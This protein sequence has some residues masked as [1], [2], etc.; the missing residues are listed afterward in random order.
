MARTG[1]GIRCKVDLNIQIIKNTDF[2]N[3]KEFCEATGLS[4][5]SLKCRY[6]TVQTMDTLLKYGID[7]RAIAKENGKKEL[8]NEQN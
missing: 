7:I 8:E 2:K 6:F 4:L 3:V 5:Q 1:D